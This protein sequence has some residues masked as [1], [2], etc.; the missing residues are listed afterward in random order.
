MEMY[1]MGTKALRPERRHQKCIASREAPSPPPRCSLRVKILYIANCTK[2]ICH[3]ISIPSLD[4]R[5]FQLQCKSS[6]S[7]IPLQCNVNFNIN[8]S[9]PSLSDRNAIEA[10]SYKLNFNNP[11]SVQRLFQLSHYSS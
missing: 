2:K 3:N 9:I 8:I 1:H 11:T 5:I 4:G 10:V 7:I 6:I